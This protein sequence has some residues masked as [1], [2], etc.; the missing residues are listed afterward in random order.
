ML[1]DAFV[2]GF[3]LRT[4]LHIF[5]GGKMERFVAKTTTTLAYSGKIL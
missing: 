5:K 2:L 3:T 1:A 4:T